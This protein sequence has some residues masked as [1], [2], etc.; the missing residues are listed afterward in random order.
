VVCEAPEA[1]TTVE[2]VDF[3]Y[4]PRC[5]EASPGDTLTIENTGEAAHTFTVGGVDLQVDVAAGE[6]AELSL[7]GVEAG[8]TYDVSCVYHPQMTAAVKVV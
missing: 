1:T 3:D 5:V 2:L 4:L 8:T 7:E 6:T